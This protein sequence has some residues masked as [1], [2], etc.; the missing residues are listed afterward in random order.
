ML[1]K[2]SAKGAS[3]SPNLIFN[4][5]LRGYSVYILCGY[6]HTQY[7]HGPKQKPSSPSAFKQ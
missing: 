2:H 3:L 7:K 4:M 5:D 6:K 1:S